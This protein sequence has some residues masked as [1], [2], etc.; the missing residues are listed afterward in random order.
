MLTIYFAHPMY[1][2]NTKQEERDVIT[3]RHLGFRVINPNSEPYQSE[4]QHEIAAG[5]HNMDYWVNLA[6]SCD[7]LAFRGCPDGAILSGTGMEVFEF[8]KTG[9]PVIELPSSINRRLLSLDDTRTFL[10]EIGER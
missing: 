4:Y 1:L 6:N 10:S 9:K 8:Q 2:Y 7:A 5:R 3:L